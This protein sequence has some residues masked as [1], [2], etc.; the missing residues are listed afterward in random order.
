VFHKNGLRA[1][2]PAK[3]SAK[4]YSKEYYEYNSDQHRKYEEIKVLW[5]E[6]LAKDTVLSVEHIKK[7]K[8]IAIDLDKRG[9]DK[10]GQKYP[11]YQC[12]VSCKSSFGFFWVDVISMTFRIDGGYRISETF[13][14]LRHNK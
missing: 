7:K 11:A 14:F 5:P 2:P 9:N 1:D 6:R 8:L 10:N 3:Y 13:F 12:T 4:N